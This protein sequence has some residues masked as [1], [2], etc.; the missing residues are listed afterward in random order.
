MIQTLI[1]PIDVYEQ[2][3]IDHL[4]SFYFPNSSEEVSSDKQDSTNRED[5]APPNKNSIRYFMTKRRKLKKETKITL[6]DLPA[7]MSLST[8][9]AI[10]EIVNYRK[11][12]GNVPSIPLNEYKAIFIRNESPLSFEIYPHKNDGI[13]IVMRPILEPNQ[14]KQKKYTKVLCWMDM[15]KI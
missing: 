12:K 7:N 4:T 11:S 10:Q 14:L 13:D 9:K 5:Q 2:E 15:T 3:K 6:T 8:Q 1:S